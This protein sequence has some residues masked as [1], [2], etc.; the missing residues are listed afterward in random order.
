MIFIYP[1]VHKSNYCFVIYFKSF[2]KKTCW[3]IWKWFVFLNT[4]KQCLSWSEGE[5]SPITLS[6]DKFSVRFWTKKYSQY[7][8][9]LSSPPL[10]PKMPF[11]AFWFHILYRN[12]NKCHHNIKLE[13]FFFLCNPYFND[14]EDFM[15]QIHKEIGSWQEGGRNPICRC[16]GWRWETP[17]QQQRFVVWP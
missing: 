2:S 8:F 10:R 3:H 5:Y 7:I 13:Q 11:I 17:Q 6:I 15:R 4:L 14:E 12:P 1:L 16:V 9:P